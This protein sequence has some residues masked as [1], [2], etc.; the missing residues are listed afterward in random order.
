MSDSSPST[1]REIRKQEKLNAKIKQ[2]QQKSR[3]MHT[4]M[5]TIPSILLIFG[6]IAPSHFLVRA[7]DVQ[8]PCAHEEYPNV[9]QVNEMSDGHQVYAELNQNATHLYFYSNYN[10]SVMN[11]QDVYRN[12]IINL[13]PCKGVVYLFVRKTRRCYPNPYSCIFLGQDSQGLALPSDC[14]WTHFMSVIDGT[15]DGAPT[16]FE[17]PLSSTKYYISV[18]AKEDSSYTLTFLSDIGAWPRPGNRGSLTALQ[19]GELTVQLSWDAATYFPEGI[20]DTKQYWVYSA[21]LLAKD[22]R[23][24][25]AVFISKGKIMNTVCGLTNNTDR[26]FAVSDEIS[27]PA[28]RCHDG[29]C[30]A[31][32]NGVITGKRYVFNVVAQSHRG[33]NMSYAGLILETHWEVKRSA[34]ANEQVIQVV[35]GVT[36][37]VLAMVT[38]IY[39]WMVNIYG[40]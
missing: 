40:K 20:S 19:R 24:N 25:P 33:F 17:L 27:L 11:Q 3:I 10:V 9:G 28:D 26:P 38:F 6:F 1:P 29:K 5:W 37:G 39:I 22:K 15:R 7:Y 31:T 13:E 21:M 36:V 8:D 18:F 16:F 35:G 23:T 32:I 4:L 12:L 30:N 34:L 2:K 14:E